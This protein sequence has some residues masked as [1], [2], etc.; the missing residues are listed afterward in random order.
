MPHGD[1]GRA[2]EKT[3]KRVKERILKDAQY[4]E[5]GETHWN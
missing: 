2:M 3:K 5:K 1:G 4:K